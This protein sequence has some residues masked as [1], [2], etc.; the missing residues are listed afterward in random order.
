MKKI[1]TL[2]S[3]GIYQNNEKEIAEYGFNITVIHPD[4]MEYPY[5]NSPRDTDAEC[6]TIKQAVSWIK[7][8]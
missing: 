3:W 6:D 1:K 4:N 7:N 8:Y 5:M 2:K